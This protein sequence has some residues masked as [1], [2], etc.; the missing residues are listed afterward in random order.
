MYMH[1]NMPDEDM[2]AVQKCGAVC[3]ETQNYP[4]AVNHADTFG[5]DS[6]LRRERS[7][8]EMHARGYKHSIISTDLTNHRGQIF[9]TNF[10][11]TP[12]ARTSNESCAQATA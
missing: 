1:N 3:I 6:V 11:Y 9:Y 7:F 8:L 5:H 10:G 2:R 12:C 4:D